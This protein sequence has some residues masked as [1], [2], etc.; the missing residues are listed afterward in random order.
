MFR[1]RCFIANSPLD[2][3]MLLKK[4]MRVQLVKTQVKVF[5]INFTNLKEKL[6]RVY[7]FFTKKIINFEFFKNQFKKKS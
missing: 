5:L 6:G 3:K 2:L 7:D 4:F 1:K